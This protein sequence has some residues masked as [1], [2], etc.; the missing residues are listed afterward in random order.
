MPISFFTCASAS[1]PAEI[2][3]ASLIRLIWRLPVAGFV[4]HAAARQRAATAI[5]NLMIDGGRALLGPPNL[6]T[7]GQNSKRIQLPANCL[8]DLLRRR[9]QRRTRQAAVEA[10]QIQCRLESHDPEAAANRS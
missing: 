3:C 6:N 5:G 2:S 8:D 7:Y 4:A 9:T 10:K 1:C